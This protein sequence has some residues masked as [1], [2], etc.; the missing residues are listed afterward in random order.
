M[1]DPRTD[2]DRGTGLQR[3]I[4]RPYREAVAEMWGHLGAWEPFRYDEQGDLWQDELRLLDAVAAYASPLEVVDTR[5]VEQRCHAW[6]SLAREEARRAG[7]PGRLDFLYAAKANM[8]SE[9]AHAA[10]RGGWHAE[11]S[12]AQDLAHLR[13]LRENDL[14]PEGLRV[15]CNGFKLPPARIRAAAP[16]SRQPAATSLPLPPGDDVARSVRELPY[17]ARIVEM[18]EAGW[19]ISPILDT[20]ELGFF[21]A[22]GMPDMKVGLRTKFGRV[23]DDAEL[24]AHVSRFGF[25]RDALFEAAATIADAPHL[26]LTT[27]HAMVGAATTMPVAEMVAALGHAGRLYAALRREH[28]TLRELNMGGGVPPLGEDYDHAGLLAGIFAELSAAAAAAEVPPPDL[29]FEF[30]SLVAAECG[31]HVFHVL[32][33]KTNAT[34]GLPW[35]IVDGGLMAAIPDM[36]L[37]DKPFRIVALS[38]ANRPARAVRLG[39]LSCDSD[40]RYP[41]ESFGEDAVVLLPEPTTDEQGKPTETWLAVL[42]VGAYQEILSGVRGAHHCGL[43]EAMELIIEAGADGAPAARVVPRQ[44]RDQAAEQL[45]YGPDAVAPLRRAM[46]G[47]PTMPPH[48]EHGPDIPRSPSHRPSRAPGAS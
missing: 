24:A 38:G 25:S 8:A 21:A 33:E 48:E 30:G 46:A 42:G 31:L 9:V 39:D 3:F 4:G 1:R 26:Q 41:P 36:L 11:T 19:D 40:G 47:R 37:I 17:A 32:H 45:G 18:A 22:E 5:R 12:S 20:G 44:T 23:D 35:A 2:P 16:K 27:L 29:T 13:W 6:M 7:Y 10:Y 14:L 28:P 43:L 34:D 15:V